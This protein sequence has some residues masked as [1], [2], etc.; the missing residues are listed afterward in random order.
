MIPLIACPDFLYDVLLVLDSYRPFANRNVMTASFAVLAVPG[1]IACMH[2][3]FVKKKR[4]ALDW[5]RMGAWF[6][7]TFV[8]GFLQNGIIMYDVPE[9]NRCTAPVARVYNIV[10]GLIRVVTYA[11]AYAYSFDRLV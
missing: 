7:G 2:T 11:F 6:C 5:Y 10:V 8:L 4:L 3:L 1:L 9:I